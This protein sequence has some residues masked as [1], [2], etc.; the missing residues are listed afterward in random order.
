MVNCVHNLPSEKF[1]KFMEM[2]NKTFTTETI[3]K[4]YNGRLSNLYYGLS[5]CVSNIEE[6]KKGKAI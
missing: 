5:E 3:S 4:F 2:T 6:I 1:V